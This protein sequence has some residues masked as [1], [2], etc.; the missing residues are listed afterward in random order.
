MPKRPTSPIVSSMASRQSTFDS[1]TQPI[2]VIE[3]SGDEHQSTKRTRLDIGKDLIFPSHKPITEKPIGEPHNETK[4][5]I[6]KLV[7]RTLK[8]KPKLPDNF[9]EVTWAKLQ[10]AIRAIHN[11]QP[12]N[13]SLEELYKACENLCLHKMADRLYSRLQEE[14]ESHLLKEKE[15]LDCDNSDDEAFLQVVDQCWQAHCKQMVAY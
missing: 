14:C 13:D 12:V 9:E 11:Y 1:F 15:K 3:H 2:T 10:A 5:P 7:I 8:D 4:I 6:K